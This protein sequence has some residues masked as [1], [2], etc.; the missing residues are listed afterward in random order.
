[1]RKTRL[2]VVATLAALTAAYPL[3]TQARSGGASSRSSSVTREASDPGY[4]VSGSSTVPVSAEEVRTFARHDE[5]DWV[6]SAVQ[7]VA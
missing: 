7:Q 2:L 4:L 3:L 5:G 1:M 6:V